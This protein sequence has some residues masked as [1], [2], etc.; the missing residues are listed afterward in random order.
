M[1]LWDYRN[2]ISPLKGLAVV[3]YGPELV[4]FGT[5]EATTGWLDTTC[6]ITPGYT[7]PGWADNPCFTATAGAS[8]ASYVYTSALGL[9]EGGTYNFRFDALEATGLSPLP[10]HCLYDS[11]G[12]SAELYTPTSYDPAIED[13]DV[14][15]VLPAGCTG[16]YIFTEYMGMDA[17][18]TVVFDN[19]SLR[20]V[21]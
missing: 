11:T 17:G 13:V 6:P 19:V 9:E 2:F 8:Q 14:T 12:L 16:V 21:L 5:G 1:S 20:K 10:K 7:F 3:R 15:V 18:G 4:S